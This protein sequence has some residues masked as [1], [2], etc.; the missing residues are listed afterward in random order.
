MT[1]VFVFFL[2][3]LNGCLV[4][5][6]VLPAALHPDPSGAGHGHLAPGL[7]YKGTSPLVSDLSGT[8]YWLIKPP[9][10][11]WAGDVSGP[12]QADRSFTTFIRY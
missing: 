8:S 12:T 5:L 4:V 7:R 11:G 6:V 2:S 9:P 10:G 3:F 1:F